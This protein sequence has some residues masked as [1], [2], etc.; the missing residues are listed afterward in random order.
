M[1]FSQS[2]DAEFQRQMIALTVANDLVYG[3]GRRPPRATCLRG[4][5][6]ECRATGDFVR[7]KWKDHAGSH[8][9]E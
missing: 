1:N 5:Y 6:A 9:P 2:F 3:K 4:A 8:P 7:M